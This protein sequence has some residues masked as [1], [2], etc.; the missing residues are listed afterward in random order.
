MISFQ[1]TDKI[2]SPEHAQNVANS[3]AGALRILLGQAPAGGACE[4]KIIDK[5]DG[6]EY[7]A[8]FLDAVAQ[9]DEAFD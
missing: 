7:R 6:S 9:V 3:L 8:V 1:P 2:E 4:C 5:T